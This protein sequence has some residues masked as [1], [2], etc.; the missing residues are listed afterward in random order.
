MSALPRRGPFACTIVLGAWGATAQAQGPPARLEYRVA[1]ELSDCPGRDEIAARVAALLGVDPWQADAPLRLELAFAP[2]DAGVGA[3]IVFR[4]DGGEIGGARELS[5]PVRDCEELSRI[6]VLTVAIALDPGIAPSAPHAP[7]GA[8]VDAVAVLPTPGASS[9]RPARSP[10]TAAAPV[11]PSPVATEP[12]PG[13]PETLHS[14]SRPVH[15]E[16][17]ARIGVALALVPSAAPIT[18]VGPVLRRG[19][20]S[21]GLEGVVTAPGGKRVP[22][23]RV[24]AWLAGAGMLPCGRSGAV[25]ACASGWVALYQARGEDL[26]EARR[27]SRLWVGLGGR[28]SAV[29]FRIRSVELSLVGEALLS[30][31]RFSLVDSR[32]GVTFWRMPRLGGTVGVSVAAP[33]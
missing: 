2:K 9:S 31:R 13:P 4:R 17:G 15:W 7:G 33:M 27:A 26:L 25:S 28:A 32:S 16:L 5:L 12:E 3:T 14:S 1:G 10:G 11:P 20:L 19:D 30:L 29:I 8:G 6:V 24:G 18:A 21:L 23:G 22:G